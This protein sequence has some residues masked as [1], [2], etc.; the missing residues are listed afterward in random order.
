M[1]NIKQ[2][3]KQ[4]KIL[5]VRVD[6]LNSTEVIKSV[7]DFLDSRQLE[8]GSTSCV[9]EFLTEGSCAEGDCRTANCVEKNIPIPLLCTTNPEFIM[10]AQKDL[11]FKNIINGS[12][13]SVPDGSGVLFANYF[14]S[15]RSYLVKGSDPANGSDLTNGS[16]GSRFVGLGERVGGADLIYEISALAERRGYSVFLLGGWPKD[17]WGRTIKSPGYDLA[18]KAADTLRRMYPRLNIIGATSQFGPNFADDDKTLDYIR[19]CMKRKAAQHIDI[20]YVC[21]GHPRQEKWVFRNMSKIPAGLGVGLGGTFD[22]I[23]GIKRRCPKF[24]ADIHLEWLFR[25][26]TQPWRFKRIVTSFL[27]FPIKVILSH[28]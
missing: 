3:I 1:Q 15:R 9:E 21:Y 18:E 25:L 17:F 10:T 28:S 2:N 5:G 27:L 16:D 20:V 12:F 4:R 8:I 11:E 24:L 14:L 13:L 26:V 7:E 6:F 22:Y 23:A 19:T